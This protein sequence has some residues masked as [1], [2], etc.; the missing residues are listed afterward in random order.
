MCVVCMMTQTFDPGRHGPDTPVFADVNE[1]TDAAEDIS[2]IYSMTVGDTFYGTISNSTDE[3]W[4]SIELTAGQTI[5][6][7]HVGI[8]LSDPYLRL[9]NS[10]GTQIAFDD[11]GGTGLNS[12]LEFTAT[13]TGA[14][15]ISADAFST[16]TG[17]YALSVSEFIPT[18]PPGTVGTLEELGTFLLEGTQ[19][20]SRSY[21][22]SSSNVISVNLDGLTAAGQQLARW[23][24]E[25][26]EMVANI[27]FV[28]VAFGSEMIT[29]DDEDSGAFAYYPNAGSTSTAHGDNTNGVELN[30]SQAW[31]TNSGTTLDSYSFQTYIHEFGHAIGLRHQ[32]NYNASQGPVTYQDDAYFTNDSWQ[33][34]VMSYFSQQENTS[35]NASYAY[36]GT[37]M[38]ADIW[39]IQELYGAPGAS[40]ATAGNTTYGQGSNL[41][42][43]L[44]EIFTALSTGS[45]TAN[46]NGNEMA[47]TLY[48]HSGTDTLAF[49]FM[50]EDLRL[51]MR[52]QQFSDFG[53][54]V[55]VLGIAQGTVIENA[56][57]GT[58]HDIITGNSANNQILA[59]SGNDVAR[60]DNGADTLRGQAGNDSLAGG[61]GNDSLTGDNGND[62]LTGENGNDL[63]L[64]GAG[65]DTLRGGEG[66]DTVNGGYG[67]DLVYMGGGNDLFIDNDQGGVYGQ[68]T[69][70]ANGG[71]DTVGGGNGN[72]VFYGQA[73]SDRLLGRLGNDQ[74]FGGNQN[75]TMEGG[76]GADTLNGGYGRDRAFLGN[77]NDRWFDNAQSQFGE[78]FV[79]GGN[80]N[81]WI[82]AGGGNDT[83]A[84][85]AGAD[86]FVLLSAIDDDV[87]TDYTVGT[88]ALDITT[89]LWNG[90]LTQG[91]LDALTHVT[92]GNLV[93]TFDNGDTLTLN[94]V[95]STAGLLGDVDLI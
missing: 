34:S 70:Y 37:A 19:G 87:I 66:N 58:G 18:P 38:M 93:F 51:D 9:Y 36:I 61:D 40:T 73:G 92:G 88:D 15:Y 8:S 46:V 17:T 53:S 82:Q 50:T 3:D 84:G 57:T 81:D 94:G 21:D 26:W 30:V 7:A 44:D 4:I 67:R 76:D 24:M 35:T 2:T 25:T 52:Q 42:N 20:F 10:S 31:L 65:F 13:T 1:T 28:E 85:G 48:D 47:F 78:D 77:G 27:N 12:L 41:G 72:D 83:L 14:Y 74:L 91:R 33:M 45:P 60:G 6:I 95:T 29:V 89:S 71:N 63:I 64:G 49:G 54:S 55:G 22:T 62:S 69:V 86:T 11:D 59:G 32:G 75:D 23:A 16:R 39:A 43:Y 68:D 5:E 80:G 56:T 79:Q 90:A